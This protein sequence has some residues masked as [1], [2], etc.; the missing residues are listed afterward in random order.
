MNQP[1]GSGLRPGGRDLL[2]LDLALLSPSAAAILLRVAPTLTPV[3]LLDCCGPAFARVAAAIHRS[4]GRARL[5]SCDLRER[6]VGSLMAVLDESRGGPPTTLALDGV[7]LLGE[8][9]QEILCDALHESPI[10]LISATLKPLDALRAGWR[11]DRFAILSTITLRVP[12]LS[13]RR[14]ELPELARRRLA[15]LAE[16]VGRPA[17]RLSEAAAAALA[18]Q[19][20]PGDLAELD[21]VLLRT[22]LMADGTTI[23]VADLRW[24]PELS[25]VSGPVPPPPPARGEAGATGVP[26]AAT[27]VPGATEAPSGGHSGNGV[28]ENRRPADDRDITVEAL[29]VELAHQL[30]NPM[31]TVKTFAQNGAQL[32]ADEDA[33][34]RFR[35]L[36]EEAIERMDSTLDELLEFSRL[37]PSRMEPVELVAM[38]RDALRAT[39]STLAG[40]QVSLTGPNGV[41]L[42]ILSDAAHLRFALRAL[43]R[44]IVETIEARSGLQIAIEGSGVLTLRYR[45]SG[46]VTHL[47]GATG[48]N[49]ASL[50]LALRMVRGAITSAGGRLDVAT[51]ADDVT[52][53]LAF[54]ATALLAEPAESPAI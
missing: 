50:P 30:K 22:L 16:A 6:Q 38:L 14:S 19:G 13:R 41:T 7:E 43:V 9:A 28:I 33:F 34:R 36:T 21:A 11:A 8:S 31:V 42:R 53:A 27:A 2:G 48:G 54:P 51:A 37:G 24:Q 10:R 32:A 3:L 15:T 39:W 49:Q 29:A 26:H 46:A 18:E 44:H 45:Q 23:D 52:I 4:S 20:W 35:T 47:R 25:A 17:P 5:V 40:K 12:A 1:E